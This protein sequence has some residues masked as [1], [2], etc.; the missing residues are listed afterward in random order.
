[1]RKVFVAG[2]KG[3]VGRAIC[4]HL[5]KQPD[6]QLITINREELDLCKQ[7]FCNYRIT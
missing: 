2:H 4:R 1:M 5:K 6:V 7:Q 3:M